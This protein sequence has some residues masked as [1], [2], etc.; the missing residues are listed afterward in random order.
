MFQSYALFPHLN[1]LDNVASAQDARHWQ[2]R[3]A[4]HAREFLN[5]VHMGTSLIAAAQLSGGQQQRIALARSLITKPR[6]LL[7]D[8]PLSALDP[9]SARAHAGEL[10]RLHGI[11]ASPLSTS[12]IARTRLWHWPI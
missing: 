1:C 4:C 12:R 11:S 9:F 3:T 10:K 2:D 6:V 8:E 5:L 7:L